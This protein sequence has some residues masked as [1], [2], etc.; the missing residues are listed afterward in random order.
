MALVSN[1]CPTI[2][3]RFVMILFFFLSNPSFDSVPSASA[4]AGGTMAADVLDHVTTA[5]QIGDDFAQAAQ[6]ITSAGIEE[7]MRRASTN[8]DKLD[9]ENDLKLIDTQIKAAEYSLDTAK[10]EYDLVLKEEE[11]LNETKAFLRSKFTNIELYG[12]LSR[13][14]KALLK[15]SYGHALSAAKMAERALQYELPTDDSFISPSNWS[16]EKNGLLA[17]EMLMSDLNQMSLFHLKNDSRFQEIERKISLRK[18]IFKVEDG[19]SFADELAIMTLT[20]SLDEKLFDMDYPGHYFRIIKTVSLSIRTGSQNIDKTLTLP[21]LTLTQTGNKVLTQPNIG[22]VE[23]LL[24]DES[25]DEEVDPNVLRIDWRSLQMTTISRW[26]E[27]NGMFNT[28]W[29]SDDRYFP[30]E[31]TGAVSSWTLELGANEW[32]AENQ[33]D[34]REILEDPESD[35]VMTVKYTANM[36][37]GKFRRA[38]ETKLTELSTQN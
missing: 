10:A 1:F 15:V 32:N 23:S 5:L 12:W 9:I 13:K 20:F 4:T 29:I 22:A 37:S 38:V 19:N 26:E 30:F 27:D 14:L 11:L 17:A 6:A 31:G 34:M 2:R 33:V 25:G 24:G 8:L 16:T 35:I 18:E 36:D 21:R 28:N 3:N 7:E